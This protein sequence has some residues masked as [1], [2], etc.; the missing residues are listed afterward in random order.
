MAVQKIQYEN[1]EALKNDLTKP[2][3]NKVVEEDMNEIKGVVNNNA[4]ELSDIHQDIE[5]L[6]TRTNNSKR[7][8]K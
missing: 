3:K 2:R 7:K 1:K 5:N 6:Q 8:H 4:D